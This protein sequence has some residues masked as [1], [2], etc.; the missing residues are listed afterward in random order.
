MLDSLRTWGRKRSGLLSV[1]GALIIFFSWVVTTALTNRYTQLKQSIEAAKST[2]HLYSTLRELRTGLNSLALETVQSKQSGQASGVASARTGD[3]RLDSLRMQF[4]RARLSSSQIN[5]LMDHVL[6]ARALAR[7]TGTESAT[8]SELEALVTRIDPLYT[9]ARTLRKSAEDESNRIARGEQ[10]FP[11]AGSAMDG[12][13]NFIRKDAMQQVQELFPRAVAAS[14]AQRVESESI[15]KQARERSELS[16]TVSLV[17][18]VLGT[19]LVLGGQ[20]F[21]KVDKKTPQ[22]AHRDA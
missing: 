13:V 19:V 2:S 7:A 6:D 20:F 18:Y 10:Q 5:E 3:E 17:L 14:N 11:A 22:D 9:R 1:S 4:D 21:D 15:L 12:Y 8:V 16:S